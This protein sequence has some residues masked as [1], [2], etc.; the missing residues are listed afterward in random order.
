VF[1][2]APSAAYCLGGPCYELPH[3]A[4]VALLNAGEDAVAELVVG[5]EASPEQAGQVVIRPSDL[6]RLP[7]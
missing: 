6:S 4:T 1:E 7:N 3:D 5:S 2:A